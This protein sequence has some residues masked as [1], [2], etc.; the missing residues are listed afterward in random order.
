MRHSD[1]WFKYNTSW[2]KFLPALFCHVL[3]WSYLCIQRDWGSHCGCKVHVIVCK[4]QRGLGI[5]LVTTHLAASLTLI[6]IWPSTGQSNGPC[7]DGLLTQMSTL[8]SVFSCICIEPALLGDAHWLV[9][10]FIFKGAPCKI[11]RGWLR[12][13]SL[14]FIWQKMKSAWNW[15]VVLTWLSTADQ[16]ADKLCAYSGVR[17]ETLHL[18]TGNF[19][20]ISVRKSA[21]GA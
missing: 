10:T 15:M 20:V 21:L 18:N 1:L 17:V 16:L 14:R 8:A 3:Y 7:V 19:S 11:F 13:G 9:I 6:R 5:F 4:L 12:R 2:H